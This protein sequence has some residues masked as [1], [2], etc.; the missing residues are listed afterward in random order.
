MEKANL[1]LIMVQDRYGKTMVTYTLGLVDR[2]I[3]K[4]VA[5]GATWAHDHHNIMIM[6]T[7]IKAML[8]YNN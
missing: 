1:N 6:G 4:D 3:S 8:K 2:G 7:N 5:V